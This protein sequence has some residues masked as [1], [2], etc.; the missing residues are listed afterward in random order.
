MNEQYPTSICVAL[1][2]LEDRGWTELIDPRWAP[3]LLEE[4]SR[5]GL[6]W[7]DEEIVEVV[8]QVLHGKAEWDSTDR[9]DLTEDMWPTRQEQINTSIKYNGFS[10]HTLQLIDNYINDILYGRANIHR[11]N[12]QEHAGLCAAGATLIVAYAVCCYARA[13]FESGSLSSKCQES[14]TSNWEIDAKQ[15]EVLQK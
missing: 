9:L 5:S 12:L 2:Y 1:N 13:S 4:F 10:E 8:N 3:E 6:G 14:G 15:E 7:T 11:F